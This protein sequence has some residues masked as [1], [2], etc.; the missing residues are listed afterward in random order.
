M[1][2]VRRILSLIIL[3]IPVAEEDIYKVICLGTPLQARFAKTIWEVLY[4]NV[5]K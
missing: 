1:D 4:G 5:R 2:E 3:G